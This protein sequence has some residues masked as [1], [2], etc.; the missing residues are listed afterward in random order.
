[1][2][3]LKNTKIFNLNVNFLAFVQNFIF[4]VEICS[5]LNDLHYK[6]F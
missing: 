2:I 6:L 4:S 5:L 1:M 3:D